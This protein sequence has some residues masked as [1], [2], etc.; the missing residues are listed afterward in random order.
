MCS[1]LQHFLPR[2]LV[3][4]I[5]KALGWVRTALLDVQTVLLELDDDDLEE[6]SQVRQSL[7]SPNS[8]YCSCTL[9]SQ[10]IHISCSRQE[11]FSQEFFQHLGA[12]ISSPPSTPPPASPSRMLRITL[13]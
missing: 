9:L 8:S 2:F 1:L 10:R 4:D 6:L 5:V 12:I 7:P 11:L 3:Q 13:R